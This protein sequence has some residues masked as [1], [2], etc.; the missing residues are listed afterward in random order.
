MRTCLV[1]AVKFAPDMLAARLRLAEFFLAEGD[2]R[3]ARQH[4]EAALR[5]SPTD[6]VALRL[7]RQTRPKVKAAAVA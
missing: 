2:L 7:D 4:A 6:P 5:L 3:Q 1:R